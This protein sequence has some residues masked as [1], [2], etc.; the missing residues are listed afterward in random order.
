M[1]N[2]RKVIY[3]AWTKGAAR[4]SQGEPYIASFRDS[5]GNPCNREVERI[6]IISCCFHYA[7]VVDTHDHLRQGVFDLEHKWVSFDFPN[8]R[9]GSTK[10]HR[11]CL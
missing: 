7:N 5:A 4:V 3:F 9:E 10:N 1:R 6:S 11:T 8:C 2:E